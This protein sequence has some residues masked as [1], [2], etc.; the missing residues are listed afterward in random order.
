M[1]LAHLIGVNGCNRDRLD[2][3]ACAASDDE[4]FGLIIV[5]M[6]AANAN[7]GLDAD[8]P[9]G[10]RTAYRGFVVRKRG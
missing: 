9:S 7:V 3:V 10:N 8:L 2:L 5:P 6:S 4:H 1:D